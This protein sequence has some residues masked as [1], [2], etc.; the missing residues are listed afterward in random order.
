[1]VVAAPGLGTLNHTALTVEALRSRSLPL[2]G[3][4][5]GSWPQPPAEPDLAMRENLADL[6]RVAGA[7]LLGVLPDGAGALTPADFQVAALDW[8]AV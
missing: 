6:P 3:V 4:V 5:V 1:V 7:P 2:V 8:L